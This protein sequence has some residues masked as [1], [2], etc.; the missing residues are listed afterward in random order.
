[1][2]T[3]GKPRV[4]RADSVASVPM[5]SGSGMFRQMLL[6]PDETPNFMMRRFT[7]E[8][9]GSAPNHTNSVEHEQY[10]LAGMAKV[11]IGDEVY[12]VS[13]GDVLYIPPGVPHWYEVTG[14]KPY[15]FLCLGPNA[16][17]EV[18]LVE[19]D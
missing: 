11:G 1:M 5:E 2:S 3:S 12:N 8:P 18:K 13:A 17:D 15:V 6:G 14:E 16:P 4:F 10:V 7:M 9:G 19:N